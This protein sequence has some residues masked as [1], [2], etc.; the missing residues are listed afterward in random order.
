MASRAARSRAKELREQLNLHNY[1]YHVL[2]DPLVSDSEYD[3]LLQELRD[4]EQQ[5]PELETEDSPTHRV[6]GG[7]SERFVRVPH[8]EPILSLSNAFSEDD[9]RAW[10]ERIA[11]LD[12]RVDKAAF[13]VEPKLD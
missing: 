10:Y 6:G 11:R 12:A 5:Y 8:P 1:R 13:V 3:Q 2:D 7:I 4:L 9:V